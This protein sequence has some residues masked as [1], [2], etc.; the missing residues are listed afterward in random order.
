MA[1]QLATTEDAES[2]VETITLAFHDDPVWSW[3]FPDPGRREQQY[4][5]WW[6]MF[7]AGSTANQ[8]LWIADSAASAAAVWVPPGE[9]EL[10]VADRERLGPVL[11]DLLGG[12]QA[13]RVLELN[14]R[15]EDHHPADRPFHYLSLLGTHPAHRGRGLG[16]D[17]LADRLE[18]LDSLQEP[19][20]LE[21]TNPVNHERYER[22][23][24]EH[25][26]QWNAPDSGPPVAVM[27]REPGSPVGPDR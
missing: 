8:A 22:L 6:A 23:G 2:V 12:Q 26:D 15:F 3:A 17:L 27:W 25:I 20:L 19:S 13:E 16:M 14:Q 1:S 5:V 11:E 7:V 9:D 18:Q 21:S 24:Y 10:L 4:R